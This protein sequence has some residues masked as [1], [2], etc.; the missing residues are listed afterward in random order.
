MAHGKWFRW[1]LG[2]LLLTAGLLAIAFVLSVL[3]PRLAGL[4]SVVDRIEAISARF[5]D[6]ASARC[7]A[8]VERVKHV[9]SVKA[10]ALTW[11]ALE[12]YAQKRDEIR[13]TDAS[14]KAQKPDENI[15]A[16]DASQKAQKPDENIRATDAYQKMLS[17]LLESITRL[18]PTSLEASTLRTPLPGRGFPDLLAALNSWLDDA[19]AELKH[20]KT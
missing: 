13:A 16:A 12:L 1:G 20:C 11:H 19:A 5:E 17:A 15:R 18:A 10:F 14:Q 7:A 9:E 2:L 3:G 8:A 4:D 6:T